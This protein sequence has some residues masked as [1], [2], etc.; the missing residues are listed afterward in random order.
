MR[1][2]ITTTSALL[3]AAIM[4]ILPAQAGATFPGPDGRIAFS[5]G[6][7]VFT[8]LPDGEAV[9]QLTAVGTGESAS[10]ASWSA[11]GRRL[12]FQRSPAG[13]TSQLWTMD[14]DGGRQRLLLDDPAY[15]DLAPSFSPN[16]GAVVFSRCEPAADGTCAIYRV[17]AG[18]GGLK[19]LTPFDPAVLDFGSAYSPDGRTVAFGRFRLDG[20]GG[21]I[22]L[23]GEDGST[24]RRLTPLELGAA[25]PDW[26]PSGSRLAFTTHCCDP[27]N[28]EIWTIRAD[29]RRLRQVTDTPDLH[30]FSPSWAPEGDAI[31]FERHDADFT[32]SGIYAVSPLG[33]PVRLIQ[34]DGAVPRWGPSL[35]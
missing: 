9:T 33:G 2:N 24:P 26:S 11:D 14:A 16:G 32:T 13:G 8:M 5:R 30:D 27:A 22:Y 18:G 12:V 20:S 28:G 15:D 17:R 31:A 10:R 7:D 3:V 21:A 25:D 1:A 19:A 4:L 34:G 23:M 29:G 6:P 35:P